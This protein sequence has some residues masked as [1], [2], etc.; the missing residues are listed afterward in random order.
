M[1]AS[2]APSSSSWTTTSD[3]GAKFLGCRRRGGWS[4]CWRCCWRRSTRSI[5]WQTLSMGRWHKPG[6]AIFPIALGLLLAISAC[7]CCW[8]GMAAPTIRC[9]RHSRCRPAPIWPAADGAGRV[10]ALLPG[11]AA[12]GNMIASALFLL[13]TMWLLSDDP[14]RSLLRLAIYAVVMA[15][16]FECVLRAAA[17]R[18]RCHGGVEAVAVLTRVIPGVTRSARTR[19]APQPLNSAFALRAPRNDRNGNELPARPALWPLRRRDAGQPARRLRRRVR[20]HRDRRAAGPRPGRRRGADPAADLLARPDRRPDHDGRHLLR[21]DV[22]RL[23]HRDPAEHSRRIR[24]RGHRDRRLSARQKGPRRRHADHRRGRLVRRRHAGGD[25]RHDVLVAAR[26]CRD[27]VRAGGIF[28]AHRR[29]PGG[30]VAD[31]RR[32]AGLRAAADD[33]RADARHRRPGGRHRRDAVSP[34]ACPISPK[35]CRWSPSWSGS[36]ALPN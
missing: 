20:R 32:H 2:S 13:A 34:S 3:A 16:M 28:R 35:A 4:A 27:P 36:T 31:L 30:D 1:T 19:F 11:D 9:R 17:A 8:N 14:G 26:Q 23:D 5:A 21:L 7:R 33:A 22:W 18:C 6:A 29:R 15:L 12:L 10:R 24:L 25:R